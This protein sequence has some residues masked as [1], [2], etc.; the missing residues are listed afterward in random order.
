[1]STLTQHTTSGSPRTCG[2]E[3]AATRLGGRG[4]GLHGKPVMVGLTVDPAGSA[5]SPDGDAA[6]SQAFRAAAEHGVDLWVVA[7]RELFT[8]RRT[9]PCTHDGPQLKTKLEAYLA[10]WATAFPEV[11]V[12]RFV[13]SGGVAEIALA[14]APLTQLVVLERATHAKRRLRGA[15][16]IPDTSEVRVVLESSVPVMVV[17]LPHLR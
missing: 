6:L 11:K 17:P 14:W 8:S 2:R 4:D 10:P 15:R 16:A 3:P 7:A 5:S 12:H 1:M 13:A 9:V